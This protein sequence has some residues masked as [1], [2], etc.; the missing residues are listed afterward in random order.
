MMFELLDGLGGFV[1]EE[2]KDNIKVN[3]VCVDEFII[4][5]NW[6]NFVKLFKY[7]FFCIFIKF[8]VV[9]FM[10]YRMIVIFF[11]CLRVWY[12]F[13]GCYVERGFS[14]RF[15]IFFEFLFWSLREFWRGMLVSI[16]EF[17]N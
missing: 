5:L 10:F 7:C 8:V 15:L 13:I 3:V 16:I 17:Y 2:W 12:G 4:F 14:W 11:M 9:F 1:I 6:L